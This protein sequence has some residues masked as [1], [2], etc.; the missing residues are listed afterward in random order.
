MKIYLVL[1][2]VGVKLANI[3]AHKDSVQAAAVYAELEY[4]YRHDP[5]LSV[6]FKEVEL[7]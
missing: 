1:E 2:Y 4:R 3:E 5:D 7:R 6:E